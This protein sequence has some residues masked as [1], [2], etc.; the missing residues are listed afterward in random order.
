MKNPLRRKIFRE[1]K[2][3]IEKYIIIFLFM[4][5]TVS[6]VSGF[7]VAGD[8]MKTTYDTSFEKY[9]VEDGN[10]E[11]LKRA[12]DSILNKYENKDI[13][14]YNNSFIEKKSVNNSTLRIFDN[15]NIKEINKV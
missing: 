8:S 2:T 3:G 12:D 9:N 4:L 11:L 13:E 5:G 6:F 1:F 14:I 7:L 15:T 10:F